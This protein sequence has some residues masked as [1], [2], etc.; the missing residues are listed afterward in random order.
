MKQTTLQNLGWG[1]LRDGLNPHGDCLNRSLGD[2]YP[3][4][5]YSQSP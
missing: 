1:T 4:T 2:F 3:Y 5:I